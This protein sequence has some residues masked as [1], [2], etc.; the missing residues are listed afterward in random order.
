MIIRA[1]T[2]ADSNMLLYYCTDVNKSSLF[3]RCFHIFPV[4]LKSGSA[5]ITETSYY[6]TKQIMAR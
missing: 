5:H 1:D 3:Q 2:E 4:N 6:I